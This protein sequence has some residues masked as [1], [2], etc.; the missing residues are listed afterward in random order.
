MSR[1]WGVTQTETYWASVI[2]TNYKFLWLYF[3]GF[4]SCK[5]LDVGLYNAM[6]RASELSLKVWHYDWALSRHQMQVPRLGTPSPVCDNGEKHIDPDSLYEKY[7]DL[8]YGAVPAIWPILWLIPSI[9]TN[10]WYRRS[11]VTCFMAPSKTFWPI[12]GAFPAFRTVPAIFPILWHLRKLSGVVSDLFLAP[13]QHSSLRTL[14]SHKEMAISI[15]SIVVE[16]RTWYV[17]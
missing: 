3:D 13:F 16:T 10:L 6:E 2:N 12:Y 7:S 14:E 4:S 15:A 5:V 8:F 11:N 9:L 17:S 1:W